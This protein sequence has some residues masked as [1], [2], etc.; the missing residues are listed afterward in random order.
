VLAGDIAAARL[1]GRAIGEL[2]PGFSTAR[3]VERYPGGPSEQARRF[4]AALSM[5]K[6]PP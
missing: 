4:G 3:Y 2:M 5:A 6:A 1:S